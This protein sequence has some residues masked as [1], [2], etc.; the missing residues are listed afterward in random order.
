MEMQNTE[1]DKIF[2]DLQSLRNSMNPNNPVR[3]QKEPGEDKILKNIF[4][5]EVINKRMKV[6]EEQVRTHPLDFM[7][8]LVWEVELEKLAGDAE[9]L[10]KRNQ[11]LYK[12]LGMDSPTMQNSQPKP[13]RKVNPSLGYAPISISSL[14]ANIKTD[15]ELKEIQSRLDKVYE[16]KDTLF[17]EIHNSA[18]GIAD[19]RI[20]KELDEITRLEASLLSQVEDI[21]LS[22]DANILL[23]KQHSITSQFNEINDKTEKKWEPEHIDLIGTAKNSENIDPENTGDDRS[24]DENISNDLVENDFLNEIYEIRDEENDIEN[25]FDEIDK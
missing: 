11:K 4:A 9:R 14:A 19:S 3:V 13:T 6:L 23:L 2:N 10:Q 22:K 15:F 8:V 7:S 20:Q 1:E 17:M 25:D 12:S 21:R 16:R 5:I 24:S 18:T